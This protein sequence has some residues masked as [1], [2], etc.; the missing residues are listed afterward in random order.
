MLLLECDACEH[1]WHSP[2]FEPC[3]ECGHTMVL[4]RDVPEPEDEDDADFLR[5]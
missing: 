4:G 5:E 3:P 2:H 1:T